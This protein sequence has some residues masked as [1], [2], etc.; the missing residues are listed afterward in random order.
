MRDHYICRHLPALGLLLAMI[1]WASSFVALKIA[2]KAYHPMVVIFGRMAVASVCFLPFIG[3]FRHSVNYQKGDLKYIVFMA[4]CEP[5]LYFL[6]E[7]KAI[8]NTT[9]SQAGMVTAMLPVLVALTAGWLLNER[10]GR[11]TWT[12]SLMAVA[13]VCWLTLESTPAG[14]A[15]HPVM[16]NIFEFLA[17]VCATGYT[18]T[19]KK[20][21]RRYA[22]FFLT[23]M[24]AFV[25]CVFYFP[26]LLLPSTTLPSGFAPVSGLAV[27]Y[28]GA[29]ITLGAYGLY[30]F[31]LKH[32][33]ASRTSAFVNLIP[34]F[35]V[36]FGWLL[37]G[38]TFTRGQC[39]AAALVMA[40]V[41]IS[42]RRSET[43]LP[44]RYQASSP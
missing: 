1:L 37:L 19:L 27:I 3:W 8:E 15:P 21:T 23:A 13:G 10:V 26:F 43:A 12:G 7:A 28:L 24:Q 17:M 9:A 33:Q 22:P 34:V 36:I 20:L 42:Q 18:I 30:N 25:G 35:S 40:G 44:E 14:D 29:V 16:G 39:L 5:C 32:I 6:F 31:G 4:F 2:F 41:Y 11:T 38:E